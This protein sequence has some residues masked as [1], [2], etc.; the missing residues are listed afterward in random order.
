MKE[1][2]SFRSLPPDQK[3]LAGLDPRLWLLLYFFK[4]N[5]TRDGRSQTLFAAP[6]MQKRWTS[7]CLLWAQNDIT[8]AGQARTQRWM[9][10]KKDV[11]NEKAFKESAK[12]LLSQFRPLG[13]MPSGRPAVCS[14]PAAL[15]PDGNQTARQNSRLTSSCVLH[16]DS[17]WTATFRLIDPLGSPLN[18]FKDC[19]RNFTLVKSL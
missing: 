8:A 6:A 2:C 4:L 14:V 16:S 15:S 11:N 17:S 18:S 10:I 13:P 3:P 19:T 5:I 1:C 9:L 7:S 12:Y